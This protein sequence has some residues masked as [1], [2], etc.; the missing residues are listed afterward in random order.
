MKNAKSTQSSLGCQEIFFLIQRMPF[1]SNVINFFFRLVRCSSVCGIFKPPRID[2][3]FHAH[4][5]FHFSSCFHFIF[6]HCLWNESK[7]YNLL[8]ES[9]CVLFIFLQSCHNSN[10]MKYISQ[11]FVNIL[12]DLSAFHSFQNIGIAN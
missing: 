4:W 5:I 7:A 6:S 11:S 12:Y 10:W 1:W 9:F 8:Y 2:I 3:Q